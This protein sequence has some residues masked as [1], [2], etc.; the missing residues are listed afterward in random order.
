M[1]GS[2]GKRNWFGV[3]LREGVSKGRTWSN[4]YLNILETLTSTYLLAGLCLLVLLAAAYLMVAQPLFKS[5]SAQREHLKALRLQQAALAQERELLLQ[6]ARAL[7]SLEAE[8][9]G[10]AAVLGVLARKTPDG[11]YLSR[12][13][14]EEDKASKGRKGSSPGQTQAKESRLWVLVEGKVDVRRFSSALEPISMMLRELRAE[15]GFGSVVSHLELASTQVSKEDPSWVSFEL[16]GI[17]S[18]DTLKGKPEDRVRQILS[19]AGSPK[20]MGAG[21]KAP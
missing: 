1:K 4:F 16:K 6:E 18:P 7:A 21:G 9:P 10:W 13:S 20:Y 19:G 3:D 17:W 11:V 2:G 14:L 12:V 15:P 8:S 5:D